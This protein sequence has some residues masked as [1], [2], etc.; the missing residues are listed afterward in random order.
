MGIINTNC[1]RL[2]VN[3]YNGFMFNFL[4]NVIFPDPKITKV[5]RVFFLIINYLKSTKKEYVIY[6][7]LIGSTPYN[8]KVAR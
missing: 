8:C 4:K 3:N 2:N 5:E 1:S 7:L 6:I